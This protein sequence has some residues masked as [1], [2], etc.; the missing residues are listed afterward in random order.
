MAAASRP[1]PS[2]AKGGTIQISVIAPRVMVV[3]FGL[4]SSRWN[5]VARPDNTWQC[6]LELDEWR[7]RGG[8]TSGKPGTPYSRQNVVVVGTRPREP[9]RWGIVSRRHSDGRRV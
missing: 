5:T 7:Y 8:L 1:T 2:A 3:A 6:S 9:T 4:T